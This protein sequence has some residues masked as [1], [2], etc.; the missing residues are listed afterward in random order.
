MRETIEVKCII[1]R[2]KYLKE[3]GKIIGKPHSRLRTIQ[4]KNSVTCSKECSRIYLRIYTYMRKNRK[5]KENE[6]IKNIFYKIDEAIKKNISREP[7]TI[8]KSKFYEEYLKIR[9]KYFMKKWVF[10]ERWN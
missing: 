4:R 3:N 2:E 10:K 1:C 8:Q 9:N 6:K 7:V 5:V